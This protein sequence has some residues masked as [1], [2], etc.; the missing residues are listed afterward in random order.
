MWGKCASVFFG[1]AA[2]AVGASA[3]ADTVIDPASAVSG[4]PGAIGMAG[5][6]YHND[7]DPGHNWGV[8]TLSEIRAFETPGNVYGTYTAHSDAYF[9]GDLT[10]IGAF[11]GSDATSFAPLAHA[12]VPIES[13][14]LELMGYINIG[15]A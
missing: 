4:T 3:Q 1:S 12:A 5:T 10:S 13:S 6:V 8:N 2:L 9:G 11:L 14:L 15:A 7:N